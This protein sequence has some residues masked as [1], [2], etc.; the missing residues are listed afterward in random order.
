[1]SLVAWYRL[2]EDDASLGIDSSGSSRDMTNASVVSFSDPTYGN[3][4][5]FNGSSSLNLTSDIP[6]SITGGNSRTFSAWVNGDYDGGT[7]HGNGANSSG[8]RFRITIRPS[9][10]IAGD[11]HTQ[12]ASTG[13][14]S[15]VDNVWSHYVC[16]YESSS[17][18]F[19][20]Y[21]NG[22][23]DQEVVKSAVN[24]NSTGTFSLGRDPTK[25]SIQKYTGYMLDF[26]IYDDVLDTTAVNV[27]TAA[28]P[29]DK[30][31]SSDSID[32]ILYS[33]LADI[34]WTV[35]GSTDG[36]TLYTLTQDDTVVLDN[37]TDT[38]TSLL[39]LSPETTYTLKLFVDSSETE[40]ITTNIITPAVDAS[41]TSDLLT[42][43]SNDLTLLSEDA[44]L[45][46]EDHISSS[47]T[48]LDTV[49]TRVSTG[50]GETKF[51]S[52]YLGPSE[53]TSVD[54]GSY[55][56][57]FTDATGSGQT[58]TMVTP[59]AVENEITYDDTQSEIVFNG[60]NYGAGSS[61]VIGGMRAI[62]YDVV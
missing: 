48:H 11:F 8:R 4:A 52:T 7:I 26:R 47:L 61:F 62:V 27:L 14:I 3:V 31:A 6:S 33:H 23:L 40:L 59:D 58:T 56:F 36:T 1:M 32:S 43:I 24:T 50:T 12:T 20:T 60:T 15:L 54:E 30:A 17:N 53:I 39:D 44:V 45:E 42:R 16:T 28:G 29:L 18:T 9:G 55:M 19:R 21:A 35:N 10:V 5:Y 46:I 37:S 38:S 41:S 34:S 51:E 22:I 13:T 49:N 57:S 25:N 2:D